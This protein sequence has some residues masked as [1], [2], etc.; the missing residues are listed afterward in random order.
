MTRRVAIVGSGVSG[1]AAAHHLRGHAHVT[2][3]E[4]DPRLGGHAHTVEVSLPSASGTI[5]HG[6]DTGFLVFNERTYPGLIGL[7]EEL[8]VPTAPSD[9]SFS[10]RIPSSAEQ[11][12]LEWGGSDLNSV[13]AQR[14]NLFRP[15]FWWMLREI[16]RFNRVTTELARAGSDAQM[17]Q[18]LSDF[19]R[20]HRFSK[21]FQ[22]WYLLPMLGCIW[23]CPTDQ[24][25][26]FPVATMIRF[27]HNHGLIQ[28][29]NRPQWWTV[30][31]GSREYV[32]RVAQHIDDIRLS[33]PVS[34]VERAPFDQGQ[35]KLVVNGEQHAFDAVV[36]A[37]HSDQCLQA[38]RAPSA[39][40]QSIL[41]A[42][43]YH[44][45][46]AVLHTDASVMPRSR[47]AWSAWNYQRAQALDQEQTQ[48]CLHYWLNALQPL[49]FTQDV[50]VSL[51]PIDPID[52][53]HVLGRYQYAHPVFD[54]AA[55]GAQAQV[56]Q[57]QGQGGVWFAGAWMGYGFHEDGYQ[58]GRQ[59]ASEILVR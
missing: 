25:L 23:S 44:N 21:G 1:L 26:A 33:S 57:L 9:M 15:R 50:I 28:V 6:V 56:P 47:R 35:V 24:M 51:N 2:L 29:S 12:G 49:P 55:I 22:N 3:F 19:L 10:A 48:V 14:R 4:Q 53:A 16:L 13:F 5:S 34:L 54:S 58:A 27:C 39:Q 36:L 37:G 38:L 7:F 40:D 11:P 59:V 42:I 52:D 18:T 43:R 17:E 30:K 20:Q 32:N 41:G 31:G 45:N 46:V 8:G